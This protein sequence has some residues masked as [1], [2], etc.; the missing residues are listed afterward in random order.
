MPDLVLGHGPSGVRMAALL[1]PDTLLIEPHQQPGGLEHPDLP[2]DLGHGLADEGGAA[3]VAQAYGDAPSLESTATSRRLVVNGVEVGLPMERG[4]LARVLP[5]EDA[6][7]V[8]AEQARIFAGSH[9]RKLVGG[10]S[11]ERTYRDWVVQRFGERAYQLLHAPYAARRWGD[12]ER[13][14]VS[15]AWLHHVAS[16]GS[17]RVA[18]GASP[19]K[20]WETLVSGVNAREAGVEVE[21]L[22]VVDGKVAS[23]RTST[24]RLEV[25]GRLFY[26]G[27][28]P[29]LVDLLGDA[30]DEGLRWDLGRMEHRHRIQ[31]A[32]RVDG[33]TGDLPAELHVVRGD[34][35]FFRVTA[36]GV[37]PGCGE[38]A[39][40]LVT[41]LSCREEDEVWQASDEE[42]ARRV[43]A[44][45]PAVGLPV[46]S[47]RGAR[48]ERLAHYDPAWIGAWHPV[49][50]RVLLAMQSLG[51]AL[52]GRSGAYQWADPG[53]EL[54]HLQA[55]AT[56]ESV[57]PRELAR[58]LLDPPVR[59]TAGRITMA[60]FVTA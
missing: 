41:H 40:V 28:L 18:L 6:V 8:V 17:G 27:P 60:E 39:S 57:D 44:A 45:L 52:S 30:L 56:A 10:G 51:V 48:V 4:R 7:R 37:L 35:P 3:V 11:E 20:G 50:V 2:E 43:V 31:V 22:E 15:M 26:T 47:A 23:V 54:L 36:P 59:G 53:R 24:G 46:A 14:N 12:P 55:L 34:A 13:L 1:G 16:E 5:H 42:I 49:L 33:D 38:L 32:V 19:A 58:T 29:R 25:D 9:L 21:A